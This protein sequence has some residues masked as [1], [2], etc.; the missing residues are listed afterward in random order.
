MA[1]RIRE[2]SLALCLTLG[3]AAPAAAVPTQVVFNDFDNCD[4]LAIPQD[5]DELGVGGSS[6]PRGPF[7]RD[8]EIQ[9]SSAPTTLTACTPNAF[10][11]FAVSITNLTPRT[12]VE[13]WYVGDEQ[14][15][16]LNFDGFAD[17]LGGTCD[18][19]NF[20]PT[21]RID[22]EISDPGGVNHPLVSESMTAND[23]FEPGETWVFVLDGYF[24]TTGLSASDLRSIG[25]G[26]ASLAG[27]SSGS[28]VAIVPEPGTAGLLALGVL[29]LAAR[30]RS[31]ARTPARASGS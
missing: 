14:T 26:S 13:V 29:G 19:T 17:A 27:A 24:N 28:I 3:L 5:V 25:V 4:P 30:R 9:A 7:P 23:I 8:E 1:M 16:L 12:F 10:E 20:C 11:N 6:I 18:L 2:T 21:F 31:G 15:G 22:S